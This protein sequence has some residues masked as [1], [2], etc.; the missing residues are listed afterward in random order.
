MAPG[1]SLY[2]DIVRLAA[3]LLVLQAHTNLRVL[4]ESIPRLSAYGHSAVVV[5]F[6]LS[7]YV[8]AYVVD[9]REQSAR[10]Y[11]IARA[12]RIYSVVIPA[13]VLALLLDSLGAAINPATYVGQSP[14]DWWVV[15]LLATVTFMNEPWGVSITAFSGPFWSVAYEAWYYILFGIYTFW[16]GPGRRLVLGV[17]AVLSGPKVLLLM[18]IWL[19]GVWV[20]RS[21]PAKNLGRV[22]A[23]M[24]FGLTI[25]A[26]AA[27]HVTGG[28]DYL[29]GIVGQLVGPDFQIERMTWS[30]EFIGD[31][32]LGALVA[33]NFIAFRS[34]APVFDR[35]LLPIA[36]PIRWAASYTF[37]LYLFHRPLILF[38]TALIH[39][40]P[41]T[42]GFYYGVVVLVLVSV[43]AL[44][45]VTEHRK[46]WFKR[47]FERGLD[48]ARRTFVTR[49]SE[50]VV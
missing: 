1:F 19:L 45:S 49:A 2:L 9:T 33:L 4:T 25:A 46:S 10:S 21:R 17:A 12:A 43:V 6:V 20:Y 37:S 7:G 15:R 11:A 27:Y 38:F 14:R 32:V 8:I 13:V 40:D 3:A 39:G 22:S 30:G 42:S 24:L 47:I 26:I 35:V 16:Q 50:A 31:Y 34:C 48:G 18:P 36:R 29:R 5:F 28:P 23:S 41:R 44:G